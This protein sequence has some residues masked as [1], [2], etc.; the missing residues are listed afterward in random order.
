[1]KR[2]VIEESSMREY[3]PGVLKIARHL[4]LAGIVI[5][6]VYRLTQIGWADI[7]AALPTSPIF[8]AIT[9]AI[10]LVL[11]ICEVINYR[12]LTGSYIPYGLRIFS[13]K[14]VY[15]DAVVGYAGEAYLYGELTNLPGFDRR[16]A[17]TVIK[18]NN[19]VSAI[20]SNSW[21]ILLVIGLIMSGQADVLRE[22]VDQSPV[23]VGGFGVICV[24]IFAFVIIFF[25]RLSALSGKRVLQLSAMHGA[26]VLI[27]AA[28]QVAQWSSG[29]PMV[30]VTTWLMFLT[31]QTLL[32]RIPGLPNSDLLF[33]GIALSLAGFAE[34]DTIPLTAMLLAAT[35]SMQVIQLVTFIATMRSKIPAVR[36]A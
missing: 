30:A 28:L 36:P 3:W 7:A 35:A 25:G 6:L 24:L 16:R 17:L 9:V 1:M 22:I 32:K 23:L 29:L 5:Y 11:P 33:L 12:L 21:T 18:D 26:K 15:N 8:Y 14:R 19:L 31:V 13:R 20:I 2:P 10:F 4:L 34:A 27:V